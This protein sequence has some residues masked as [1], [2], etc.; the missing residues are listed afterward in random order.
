MTQLNN[1]TW[2]CYILQSTISNRTY[3]GSTNNLERRLKQHNG[4]LSGGAKATQVDRPYER[5]C[6]LSGFSTHQIALRVEWWIKHPTGAKKRP[7]KF[8]RPI[9]RIKG[10]DFL[11]EYSKWNEKFINENL[12][13]NIKKEFEQYLTHIPQNVVLQTFD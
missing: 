8:N 5:I 11:F 3:N 10:L 6:W 2:H 9:G 7:S 1:E 12:V 4:I 13:C